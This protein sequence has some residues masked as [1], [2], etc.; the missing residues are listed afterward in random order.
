M[1]MTLALDAGQMEKLRRIASGSCSF[2]NVEAALRRYPGRLTPAE[3][4]SDKVPIF[5][6]TDACIKLILTEQKYFALSFL[7]RLVEEV[8]P[9]EAVRRAVADDRDVAVLLSA[10]TG[11]DSQLQVLQAAL[12]AILA[13]TVPNPQPGAVGD[14]GTFRRLCDRRDDLGRIVTTLEHFEALKS[15]HDALHMVQVLGSPWLDPIGPGPGAQATEPLLALLK[16]VIDIATAREPLLDA[17]GAAACQ[18]CVVACQEAMIRIGTD[19]G[20]EVAFARASLRALL[21]RE[22][23]ALDAELFA[24]SRGF[25]LRSFHEIFTD[26]SH[27]D[28]AIDLADTLGRRVMSHALWQATDLRIGLIEQALVDAGDRLMTQLVDLVPWTLRILTVLLDEEASR[29]VIPRF[30]TAYFTYSLASDPKSTGQA[31]V[32]DAQ[33]ELRTAFAALRDAA[34]S[35]FL[36]ADHA[37]LQDFARLVGLN[38]AFREILSRVPPFCAAFY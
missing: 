12:G 30:R 10:P 8:W 14:A 18:R 21:M 16:R 1:P 13:A 5:E 25:P 36:A 11:F 37:L 22:L 26:P 28:S 27:R 38:D 17:A 9:I 31:S 19:A 7:L 4:Y 23:P 34:R 24:V 15:V 2:T 20:D 29:R 32:A 3:C 33:A 35:G 6:A